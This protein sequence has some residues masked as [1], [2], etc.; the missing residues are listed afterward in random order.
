LTAL[1][2]VSDPH[3]GTERPRVV[4]A[5]L[6][7]ATE[8]APDGVVVSGDITQ[9]ARRRQFERARAFVDALPTG[10]RVVIPGNHDIPLGNVLARIAWPYG[11]YTRSFGCELEPIIAWPT[12]L[13]ICVNTTRPYRHKHGEVSSHQVER[14]SGR[15]REATPQQARIVVVHQPVLAVKPSDAVNLLRGA[16]RAVYAW[17]SAGADLILGGHI[18]LPYVR[19]L[20]EAYPGIEREVF[21]AQAGTAV[22]SRVRRGAPNSVNLLRFASDARGRHCVVERWDCAAASEQ[23]ILC[24]RHDLHFDGSPSRAARIG[25]VGSFLPL[26]RGADDSPGDPCASSLNANPAERLHAYQRARRCRR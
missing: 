24:E 12:V 14:V 26:S 5:L 1:L 18:H 11:N 10:R 9:R 17:S 19:P 22:S 4:Q 6:R 3:F 23:F 20:R 13:V 7:L 21:T 15:L 2:H 25:D 8:Q 16:E